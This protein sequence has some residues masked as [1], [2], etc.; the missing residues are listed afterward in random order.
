MFKS[1][2]RKLLVI[3]QSS[4]RDNLFDVQRQDR[5]AT[6]RERPNASSRTMVSRLDRKSRNMARA[7][8]HNVST[9]A[10]RE[11]LSLA[12]NAGLYDG[13][14]SE[15]NVPRCVDALLRE[16]GSSP[17]V[18][19]A[20]SSLYTPWSKST[21]ACKVLMPHAD[22]QR[23]GGAEGR[24]H[25]RRECGC[26]GDCRAQDQMQWRVVQS[27]RP[28]ARRMERLAR[29]VRRVGESVPRG[30]RADQRGTRATILEPRVAGSVLL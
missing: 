29:R 11:T 16:A 17:G 20:M 27:S 15:A 26:R 25:S 28:R 5:D 30:F 22:G 9:C 12:A 2:V 23:L 21:V 6:G 3:V 18:L 8:A 14:R 13:R 1:A 7:A 4:G 19:G 24:L 10:A